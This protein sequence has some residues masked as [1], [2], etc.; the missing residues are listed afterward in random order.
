MARLAIR[1]P[2][3]S[4]LARATYALRRRANT[5]LSRIEELRTFQ[6]IWG[7]CGESD[8]QISLLEILVRHG[9]L[10]NFIF[11][12]PFKEHAEFFRKNWLGVC[13]KSQFDPDWTDV[14]DSSAGSLC[15]FR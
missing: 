10:Q 5:E 8:S 11:K 1:R 14:H 9:Y 6:M 3:P 7:G 13:L 15:E 4:A 2:R 12:H